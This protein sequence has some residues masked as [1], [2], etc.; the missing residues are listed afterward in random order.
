MAALVFGDPREGLAQLG[1]GGAF[2][3]K[4][5]LVGRRGLTA[6][7]LEDGVD[8][9]ALD[10]E[11]FQSRIHRQLAWP[12]GLRPVAARQ[13][14]RDLRVARLVDH[15]LA[16][17][18]HQVGR[19]AQGQEL[20]RE[21]GEGRDGGVFHQAH[22][23]PAGREHRSAF[24]SQ[25]AASRRGDVEPLRGPAS[26]RQSLVSADE[27]GTPCVTEMARET[28][29]APLVGEKPALV[30]FRAVR[31]LG[32]GVVRRLASVLRLYMATVVVPRP[33]AQVVRDAASVVQSAG[34]HL[35]PQ[36]HSQTA[37]S[38]QSASVVHP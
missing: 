26:V 3:G 7:P 11:L 15:G 36:L 34:T 21:A 4:R 12:D 14:E 27:K 18:R 20:Q 16:G 33:E 23:R 10:V 22:P 25:R 6:T 24:A 5:Y 1:V 19:S 8:Q 13:T 28:S 38:P 29:V 37:F 30:L 35:P 17:R 32:A 9:N 2:R 31:I